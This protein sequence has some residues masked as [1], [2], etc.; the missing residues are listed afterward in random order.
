MG[1]LVRLAG[2]GLLPLALVISVPHLSSWS[3]CPGLLKALSGMTPVPRVTVRGRAGDVAQWLGTY[4]SGRG[5]GFTSSLTTICN[6]SSR[7]LVLS[8][9]SAG[10]RR[11]DSAGRQNT[12]RKVTINSFFFF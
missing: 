4:C 5:P 10:T 11:V 12:H 8:S 2:L 1:D 7:D 3:P 6:S 9:D